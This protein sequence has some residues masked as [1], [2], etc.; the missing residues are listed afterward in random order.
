MVQV[1]I[2]MAGFGERFRRAGYDRPKPLIEVH[3]RPMIAHVADLF[4]GIDDPVFLCNQDH[5]D[6][7]AWRMQQILRECRPNAVVA[8]VSPHRKGPVH[9]LI[10]GLGHLR[11]DEPVLVC[12]CDLNFAWDFDH[13]LS[14]IADHDPDGCVVAYRG[15]HPHLLHS[16]HYAFVRTEEGR[17]VE[18]REKHAFTDDPITN[19]EYCSNGVYYW[20]TGHEMVDALRRVYAE[21]QLAIAGEHY[22]SQAFQPMIEAGRDVVVYEMEHYCQWGNPRDLRE[23]EHHARLFAHRM[24]PTAPAPLAGTLL[25]PMAGM[26]QRFVDEGWTTPKPLLTVN[27]QPMAV[28]A[29]LDLPQAQRQVFVVR[30]DMPGRAAV[31]EALTEAC[32]DPRFVVLEQPTD[33][34]ARTCWLGITEGGVPLDEPLVIGTCD[35]GL[36]VEGAAH[37]AALAS[38]DVLVWVVRGHPGAAA[39]PRMYGW[40]DAEGDRVRRLSV[41]EPLEDPGT[42]PIVVGAFSFARAGDFLRCAERL[43][44]RGARVR[45]E[46]YV[47][48]L[49]D[50]AL[51]LGLDVRTFEV[52][53]YDGW[54]TPP[55]L[56]TYR[57]WQAYFHHDPGHAYHIGAD[58]SVAPSGREALLSQVK[59]FRPAPLPQHPPRRA[60]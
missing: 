3:G 14:W 44:G 21:P 58:P 11:L 27:G 50:D 56:Q 7:P 45:G 2:P 35:N 13:F 4:P 6:A 39:H 43:F 1:V 12:V 60:S 51:A 54:G 22:P 38:A 23:Y 26:G 46:F 59:R 31:Q 32:A 24:R 20:R 37:A 52:D 10:A 49:L 28:A 40:V 34:Q 16:V 8:G 41:K 30:R 33:G 42:D 36:G 25:V 17:A 55:D 47:D 53:R 48:T 29:T 5:L 18:I 57:Y 19:L 15:F 9:T